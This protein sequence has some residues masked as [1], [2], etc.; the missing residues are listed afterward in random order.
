MNAFAVFWSSLVKFVGL[1]LIVLGVFAFFLPFIPG[2]VLV[3]LGLVLLFG[4]RVVRRFRMRN[5]K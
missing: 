4:P 5:G 2:F 1:V 3:G